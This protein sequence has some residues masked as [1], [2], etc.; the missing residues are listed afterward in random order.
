MGCTGGLSSTCRQEETTESPWPLCR[1]EDVHQAFWCGSPKR[2]LGAGRKGREVELRCQ[3]CTLPWEKKKKNYTP[4]PPIPVFTLPN[5]LCLEAFCSFW[6]FVAWKGIVLP[7]SSA[8]EA[9]E[10]NSPLRHPNS[11]RE[12]ARASVGAQKAMRISPDRRA[13]TMLRKSG[14]WYPLPSHPQQAPRLLL[15]ARDAASTAPALQIQLVM[16][17]LIDCRFPCN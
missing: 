11:T 7:S 9:E 13:S 6:E 10:G 15:L 14:F 2:Q 5:G 1:D 3:S 16:A 8:T 17:G 4:F 12:E